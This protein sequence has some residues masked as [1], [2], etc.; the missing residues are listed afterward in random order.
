[1]VVYLESLHS[2]IV[3]QD[4]IKPVFLQALPVAAE[5]VFIVGIKKKQEVLNDRNDFL[6]AEEVFSHKKVEGFLLKL[7]DG[8]V[9][10]AIEGRG[11]L[12]VQIP[13]LVG[14]IHR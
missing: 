1:M 7:A 12:I 2:L 9:R 11:D 14:V 13:R 10:D 4:G 6:E 5:I 3:L 8:I